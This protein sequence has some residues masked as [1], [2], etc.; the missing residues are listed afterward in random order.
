MLTNIPYII[1][2]QICFTILWLFY[3]AALK[4]NY[5][6]AQN[7]FYLLSMSI[8]AFIIPALE[9][10]VYTL[11]EITTQAQL[12]KVGTITGTAIQEEAVMDFTEILTWLYITGLFVMIGILSYNTFKIYKIKK[13]AHL[14]S[15]GKIQVF[16]SNAISS[17][18]SFMNSIFINTEDI[19]KEAV[20]QVLTHEISHV[21]LG[22]YKDLILAQI[23]L[24]LFWWNPFVW[25][26]IRS[27]K[28]VHEFQADEA[29]LK[30]CNNS[31]LYISLMLKGIADIHPEFV[32][33]FSYSLI[34]TRLTMITQQNKKRFSKFRILLSLPVLVGLMLCFSC[35][36]K[37]SDGNRDDS[38]QINDKPIQIEKVAITVY[39]DT[40]YDPSNIP[41]TDNQIYILAGERITEDEF[42]QLNPNL[43]KTI[44][45][46]KPSSTVYIET[47]DDPDAPFIKV[48]NPP[49]FQGGDINAFR[50]WVTKQIKY[51]KEAVD[52]QISGVVIVNFII[53]KDGSL[54]SINI[55]NEPNKLLSDEIIRIL[56]Q[57]PKWTPGTQRGETVRVK[58][59][60]PFEFTLQ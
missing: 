11:S 25:L 60:M 19:G 23:I 21:K 2:T 12:I 40:P 1:A 46:D 8:I 30:N 3:F 47:K 7:R 44:S 13:H 18:F 35:T 57:S 9:I 33:G 26:W 22:H 4:R 55:A 17:S 15:E 29:V 10:P 36:D 24:I 32:S 34:K 41:D 59:T 38:S 28:E 53:E 14:I 5:N 50:M 49:T 37:Q 42:N 31:E 48:E 16:K 39:G 58:F 43:I 52:K 54:S 51:P 45:L 27:L 20:E 56:K 6:F